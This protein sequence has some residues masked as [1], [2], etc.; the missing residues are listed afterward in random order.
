MTE[1]GGE[2]EGKLTLPY[3]TIPTKRT[4]CHP[5]VALTAPTASTETDNLLK[6]PALS[7]RTRRTLQCDIFPHGGYKQA[8][9][10]NERQDIVRCYGHEQRACRNQ[11][12]PAEM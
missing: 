7:R 1:C 12:D 5:Y 10:R 8:A 11:C 4:T 6:V 2:T 9:G 3:S